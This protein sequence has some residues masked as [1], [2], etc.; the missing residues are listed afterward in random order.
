MKVVFESFGR[1]SHFLLNKEVIIILILIL[2]GSSIDIT[3]YELTHKTKAPTHTSKLSDTST[4]C[5]TGQKGCG[6]STPTK[7]EATTQSTTSNTTNSI[8][9][10]SP[11][12][13]NT[14]QTQPSNSAQLQ[15]YAQEIAAAQEQCT[16]NDEKAITD[17][18]NTVESY[19]ADL[20]HLEESDSSSWNSL[21]Q[22]EVNSAIV[23][24]NSNIQNAYNGTIENLDICTPSTAVSDPPLYQIPSCNAA[25]GSEL[26]TCAEQIYSQS[27][28][29]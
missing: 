5:V 14:A 25:S 9:K 10:A 16:S 27:G 24:T 8:S 28:I 26:Q 23:S 2:V 1:I 19:A 17:Y 13:N 3:H 22:S 20:Y 12:E 11:Q 29:P 7:P 6:T 15:Q 4:L 18:T 21:G